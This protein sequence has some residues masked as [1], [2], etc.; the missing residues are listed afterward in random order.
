ME[1]FYVTPQEF[2]EWFDR[3][4]VSQPLSDYQATSI[5]TDTKSPRSVKRIKTDHSKPI[6][7][8]I[9]T[10]AAQRT[11][12]RYVILYGP[13]KPGK[14]TKN[15][16]GDGYLSL[17]GQMAHVCDLKGRMLEEPTLLDDVDLKMVEDLGELLIGSTEI[18]IVEL[19]K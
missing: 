18:Q 5:K 2:W 3:N 13:H 15:W 6:R 9:E 14:K 11:D 19:D 4:D 7:H 12:S 1:T 17:V 10:E 8:I 16:T